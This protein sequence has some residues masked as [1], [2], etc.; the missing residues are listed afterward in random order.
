MNSHQ[1]RVRRRREER[2]YQDFL[3]SC[4]KRCR[5]CAEC[6]P[7]ICGGVQQ[8]GPCDQLCRC[9]GYDDDPGDEYDEEY[10]LP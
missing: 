4:A 2:G 9:S 6:S 8:G 7:V 10:D 5:C 1:R 3:D